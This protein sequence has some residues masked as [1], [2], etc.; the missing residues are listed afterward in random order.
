MK[1]HILVA[2]DNRYVADVVTAALASLDYAVVVAGDG[3]EAVESAISLHP[4]LI[5]MDM[6]MPKMDGFQAVA[7]LRKHPETE[8][9][10]ILAATALVGLENRERCLAAGC[11]GYITKPFTYKEL[12][13]AIEKLLQERSG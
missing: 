1:K 9:I 4:D 3:V 11:N 10:P 13:A 2:E 7:Q 8:S 5:V 12:A 6:M